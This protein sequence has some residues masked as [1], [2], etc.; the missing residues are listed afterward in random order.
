[1]ADTDDPS[2]AV[3]EKLSKS[4]ILGLAAMAIGVF[5]IANDFTSLAVALP[6]MEK[7]FGVSVSTIQWVINGYAMVFGVL[8]VT[9]GRLADMFGR[10]V[11]F[12]LGSAIF[13]TFSVIGG[14]APD[15]WV[16][17]GARFLMGVGGALMWPA[18][19]G[20][21]YDLL[22][23]GK[24]GLAGGIVMGSAGFGNAVGPLIGG[25]LTDYASWRWIFFLNLPVAIFGIL[26]TWWVIPK[27]KPGT[28]ERRI[29]YAGILVLSAGLL[30]LLLALDEGTS[31]GWFD[32]RI[33]GLFVVAVLALTGFGFLER[34]AG[35]RAL[36][37]RD[38]LANRQFFFACLAVLLMSAL[39]FA[40]LLY[41]P[42]YMMK[43]LDYSA[44]GAGAGLLP[45]MGLFA[46]TSFIAGP[47]YNRFGAKII[48]GLGAVMLTAGMFLLTAIG[49]DAPYTTLVPGMVVLGIGVGLFYSSITTAGITALDK[50]RGS[51]AGAIIYMCQIAGGSIGLGLNTAIVVSNS[52]LS[53][54][55]SMAF[56]VDGV[57][58]AC[59]LVIVVVFVGG[60]V[61]KKQM[62][63]LIHRHRAHG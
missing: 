14:L 31:L 19:L 23:S 39:F 32:V 11:A 16:V 54:G 34:R 37:P 25:A 36:V 55:I 2:N 33:I 18:I 22:P 52:T 53:D 40:A 57:L 47:A 62:E 9:G 12:F 13:A 30:A 10:R 27:D 56:L 8:I 63:E 45:M 28:G 50:S 48:V 46:V 35:D 4:T 5:V 7:D 1:M 26:V 60:R 29:D 49:P 6:A 58:A 44:I 20:M 42:Q 41:L 59:A 21:T 51:L 61:D 3:D 43:K 17:L 38:V 15:V 24:A